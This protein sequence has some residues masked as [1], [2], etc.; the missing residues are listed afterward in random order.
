LIKNGIEA[1]SHLPSSEKILQVSVH[2]KDRFAQIEVQD[3]GVGVPE[4]I[5]SRLFESFF[6]TKTDGM[7]MGLNIC[8]TIIEYHQ[9]QLWVDSAPERGSIF[10]FTL[11]LANTANQTERRK[12]Q[13]KK[14]DVQNNNETF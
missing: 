12:N 4:E 11:P 7:G 2:Q 3:E 9:G 14:T 8:R 10:K 5:K 1:M 13:W 6:T